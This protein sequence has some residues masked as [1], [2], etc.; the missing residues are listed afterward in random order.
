M[1]TVV[2]PEDRGRGLP[3]MCLARGNTLIVGPALG[4]QTITDDEDT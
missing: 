3:L 2:T 1:G 4:G